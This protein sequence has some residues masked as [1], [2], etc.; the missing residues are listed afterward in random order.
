MCST[1]DGVKKQKKWTTSLSYTDIFQVLSDTTNAAF[2]FFFFNLLLRGKN[3][4]D[5]YIKI[6]QLMKLKSI[7]IRAC[8]F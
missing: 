2:A 4:C 7:L 5:I 1:A 6:S 3:D 8:K